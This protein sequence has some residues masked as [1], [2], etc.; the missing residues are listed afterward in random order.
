M[1]L[2]HP[3]EVI[4][5]PPGI[6]RF[7]RVVV[8]AFTISAVGR[9]LPIDAAV[10]R[11]RRSGRRRRNEY[12][13][14][15]AGGLIV[16]LVAGVSVYAVGASNHHPSLNAL[17]QPLGRP[18][19][20]V[21]EPGATASYTG[22]S[23]FA[24][25]T[26]AQ[27]G[28]ALYYSGWNDPFQTRFALSARAHHTT[29]FVQMMPYGVSLSSIAAGQSDSYLRSFA[30]AV[31][32]FGAPVVI[33]FGPEMNGNWYGWGAGRS[34]PS[35]FVAAWQHVVRT[36]RGAGANNVTWLWTINAVN[37]AHSPLRQW[38]PGASYVTWV[39]IDGYYYNPTDSFGSVFGVTISQL[40]AFTAQPVLISETAAGPS[41]AQA[42]QIAGLFRGV[43]QNHLVGVVWFDQAQHDGHFH[44]DWR[45]EDSPAAMRAFRAARAALSPAS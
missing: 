37:V 21:F 13:L 12:A 25:V 45:L 31:R 34:K 44:Q 43:Q 24:R 7:V 19:V 18:L 6:W 39:G 41:P 16:V 32:A 42:A 30:A 38:W 20:G 22:V 17:R 8:L 10:R 23:R 1:T 5:G 15:G 3:I 35:T 27:P 4:L 40:R 33:G 11:A 28:I 14:W 29:P 36:F 9:L 26:G 2:P